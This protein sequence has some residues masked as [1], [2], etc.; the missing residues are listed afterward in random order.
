MENQIDA[1]LEQ[2]TPQQEILN[3]EQFRNMLKIGN[4]PKAFVNTCLMLMGEIKYH[5][6]TIREII[7]L[8]TAKL[9]EDGI[10]EWSIPVDEFKAVIDSNSEVEIYTKKV[11]NTDTIIFKIKDQINQ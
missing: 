2:Q 8:L 3:E 10:S 7:S 5:Q 9:Q 4:F 11:D 1:N 6:D